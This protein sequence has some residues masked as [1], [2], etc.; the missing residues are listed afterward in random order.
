MNFRP[1]TMG[2]TNILP[3]G[4]KRPQPSARGAKTRPSKNRTVEWIWLQL[5][6]TSDPQ[7]PGRLGMTIDALFIQSVDTLYI[8]VEPLRSRGCRHGLDGDHGIMPLEL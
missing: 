5:R 4:G 3:A 1:S 7:S 2:E 8:T 6:S